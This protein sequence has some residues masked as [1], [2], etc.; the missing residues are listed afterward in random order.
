MKA[1]VQRAYGGSDVLEFSDVE[2]PRIGADEVLLRVVAAGVDRGVWHL[3]TGLP[4]LVRLA[5]YGVRA[6][7]NPV[8]GLDVAGVVER[9]GGRVTGFARGDEV[10]GIAAGSFA[11]FARA[12]PDKLVVKPAGVGFVEAA[13]VGV[14]GLAAL[15]GL[16][17]HGRVS[18][19][20]RV[21]IVGASGGVGTFAVQVAKALGAHVTGVCS[22]SKTALVAALGADEIIDYTREDLGA[23]S[24]NYDVVLDIG[25]N[26]RLSTLRH[27]LAPEGRLVIVG[28]EGG[29]RWL[30]GVDRQLRALLLSPFLRQTLCTFISAENDRDLAVLRDFMASKQLT[31]SIDTTYELGDARAAVEHVSAGRARGKVALTV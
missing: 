9:V 29:G 30:G 19:G 4:Y 15:Q 7:R 28:G 8:P 31:P 2:M 22:T 21:L 14:S 6:P 12:R 25:G 27:V 26:R 11:E 24:G 16:R 10:F 17:D 23:H 13:T 3:M 20:Q 1:I 5:G 18:G